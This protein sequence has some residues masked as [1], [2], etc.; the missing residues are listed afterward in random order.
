[1]GAKSLAASGE[2]VAV[3]ASYEQSDD[4]QRDIRFDVIL[5][6]RNGRARHITAAF[7]A[8]A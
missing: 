4:G 5:V 7:D 3:L 8:T 6:A 1:M 2:N